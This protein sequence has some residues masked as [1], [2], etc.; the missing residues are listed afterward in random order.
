MTACMEATATTVYLKQQT[1]QLSD[2]DLFVKLKRL[3]PHLTDSDKLIGITKS[4]ALLFKLEYLTNE[5][6]E[7]LAAWDNID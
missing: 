7:E 3:K 5:I 6:R 2:D 1:P 4:K